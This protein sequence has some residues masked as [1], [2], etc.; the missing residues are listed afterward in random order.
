[1]LFQCP[2]V[3]S[4]LTLRQKTLPLLEVRVSSVAGIGE[5]SLPLNGSYEGLTS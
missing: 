5:A 4:I 2:L 3:Q 1:M